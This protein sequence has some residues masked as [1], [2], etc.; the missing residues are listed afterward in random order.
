MQDLS[1]EL[2]ITSRNS[3]NAP[4]KTSWQ[5]LLFRLE[6]MS[7]N[8]LFLWSFLSPHLSPSLSH[9]YTNT[10]LSFSILVYWMRVG[11][12]IIKYMY[13]QIGKGFVLLLN[14]R[15][16]LSFSSSISFHVCVLKQWLRVGNYI[17]FS[18]IPHCPSSF[19][20]PPSMPYLFFLHSNSLATM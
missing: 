5:D 17:T 2:T 15:I 19:I 12:L 1:M 9:I 6:S 4:G 16:A 11:S 7:A 10:H 3:H 20:S 8:L 13:Y 14:Q 18:V